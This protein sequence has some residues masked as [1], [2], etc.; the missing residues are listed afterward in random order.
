MTLLQFKPTGAGTMA[1]TNSNETIATISRPK[2]GK[3]SIAFER[4]VTPAELDGISVF[5]HAK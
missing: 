4:A 2:R 1:V 5:L 3:A